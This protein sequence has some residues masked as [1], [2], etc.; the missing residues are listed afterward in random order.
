MFTTIFLS[1]YSGRK[2]AVLA[3]CFSAAENGHYQS[4]VLLCQ[5]V[6]SPTQKTVILW[7][8]MGS[9]SQQFYCGKACKAQGKGF[10]VAVLRP[11]TAKSLNGASWEYRLHISNNMA[12]SSYRSINTIHFY[13]PPA[14][15]YQSILKI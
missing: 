15:K 2:Q 10:T 14:H 4:T 6:A 9:P 7:E 12:N 11:A 8:N 3:I 13:F 5:N 1:H